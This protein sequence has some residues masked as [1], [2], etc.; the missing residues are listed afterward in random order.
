MAVTGVVRKEE[1]RNSSVAQESGRVFDP[2]LLAE[3]KSLCSVTVHEQKCLNRTIASSKLT[4]RECSGNM[5]L[6]LRHPVQRAEQSCGKPGTGDVLAKLSRREGE[7]LLW[8]A[9]GKSTW[10]ISRILHISERT[11]YFHVRNILEKLGASS[12]SHA[13]SIAVREGMGESVL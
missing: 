8:L 5:E 6:I 3:T 1:T 9:E 10:E 12:R 4:R 11:V 7:V 13:V 2:V